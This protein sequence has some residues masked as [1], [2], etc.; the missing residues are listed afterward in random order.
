MN[1]FSAKSGTKYS[2]PTFISKY[3]P[4]HLRDFE[5]PRTSYILQTLMEIGDLNI[6]L[7]GGINSGK[8]TLLYG[9]LR[10]YYGLGPH[11]N[12]PE[13]NV[14]FINNLE[15][16][17]IQYFRNE[18]KTFCQSSCTI[19]RKKKTIVVDDIDAVPKQSQQVFR[20]CIDKYKNHVHFISSCSNTQKVV[21]SLQ[22]RLHIIQLTP[23]SRQ[24]IREV[25]DRII[26]HEHISVDEGAREYLLDQANDSM[27]SIMNNLEKISLYAGEGKQM[28]QA[29]CTRL[30]SNI[31]FGHFNAYILSAK[32]GQ[33][34]ECVQII[35]AIFDYG[36]SV[37]DI[38]EYMFAFIK[39]TA[40]LSDDEKYK[41]IP[42]LC[43]FITVFHDTHEHSI[44]LALFTN[45]VVRTLAA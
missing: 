10:E 13:A 4:S 30:C 36:Y 17:G 20:N 21:E 42:H 25:M 32:R 15:E 11:A 40:A 26:D 1:C 14:L 18:L 24:Q 3:T 28:S 5:A 41:L 19:F 43:T 9:I 38:L 35:N 27:R 33:L 31:S 12:I 23:P 22:S 34:A 29:E 45:H 39:Q 8:T 6:L 2:E 44:E 7:I 16:Q 37:I